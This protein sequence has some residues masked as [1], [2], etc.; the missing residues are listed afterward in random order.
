LEGPVQ[1]LTPGIPA[2]RE[3]EIGRIEVQA[4][5]GINMKLY[6]ENN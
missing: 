1:W 3:V 2:A 5:T 6:L 4:D